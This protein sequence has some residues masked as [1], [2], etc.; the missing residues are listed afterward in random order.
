MPIK[1]LKIKLGRKLWW[2]RFLNEL[3]NHKLNYILLFLIVFFALF[4]RVYKTKDLLQFYYDQGRDALV[5]W[6][7]W[8]E[9]K[10]FLI[11]PI[12]GLKGIFL[13]PLYYYIIAPFYLIG[14]GN[15]VY[16]ALFLSSLSTASLPIVYILGFHM[17]SRTTGLVA[18]VIAGFSYY[19]VTFSRW[20]S[21]PNLILL[22]SSILLFCLWKIL[23][24]SNYSGVKDK[25][26]GF[27]WVLVFLSVGVSLQFE[28]ASAIFYLPALLVFIIWMVVADRAEKC[29]RLPDKKTLLFCLVIF[30]IT[31]L[32]QIIF[33]F[34]HENILLN[35]FKELIFKEKAFR[36]FNLD[37]LSLRAKYF[38]N[39]FSSKIFP[40]W[41]DYAILFGAVCLGSLIAGFREIKKEV[42]ILFSIFLFTPIAFYSLFQGNYGNI[43]DYYMSGY[44]YVFILFFSVSLG[45]LWKKKLGY[46]I[47]LFFLYKFLSL[48]G[49]LLKN[50]L[51]SDL[52]NRPISLEEQIPAIDWIIDDA[53]NKGGFNLNIY[54]PPVIP[55]SYDYLYL[56][57][58]DLRSSGKDPSCKDVLCGL[59][60]EE[61]P[62]VY[63]LIE[64]DN[65]HPD[66]IMAWIKAQNEITKV[67]ESVQIGHITLERRARLDF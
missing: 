14:G 30:A 23:N 7:L 2:N 9:G 27:W 21:N 32:P 1:I 59:T 48:N 18:A 44:Y 28:S 62:F 41:S 20:L 10:L 42:F 36:L 37:I 53:K 60:K 51:T 34:R 50:M 39:V 29:R 38:W 13:G 65:D 25:N 46:I 55:Y 58:A 22:T 52:E 63:T 4:I 11:G 17:H 67:E 19:I 43:Y 64:P 54:V 49:M 66:R 16:P 61:A 57:Q 5:I 40:G 24:Y 15:P 35:N 56:W 8:H 3:K 45:V 33:N 6:D 12:T 26:L 47:V 31:L